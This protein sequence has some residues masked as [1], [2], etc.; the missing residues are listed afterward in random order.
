MGKIFALWKEKSSLHYIPHFPQ[1]PPLFH[2]SRCVDYREG[3]HLVPSVH[4]RLF[5]NCFQTTL[6][7][8]LCSFDWVSNG[9]GDVE[10]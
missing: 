5:Q 4:F 7:T 1:A 3:D 10:E 2:D 8:E 9:A 6:S